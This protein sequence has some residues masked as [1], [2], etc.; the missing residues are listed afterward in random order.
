MKLA[1][2]V[3]FSYEEENMNGKIQKFF[4]S[5]KLLLA[6]RLLL[7]SIFVA[8]SIG[9]LQHPGEFTTLVASYNILPYSLA[10]I[11]GYLVPWVELIIGAFLILGIL[12]RFASAL[13]IPLIVS[14][15]IA[16]SH[17]LLIGAGGDVAA[18]V[19]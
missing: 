7:G 6:S 14:F 19:M 9:K 8:A 11:Y 12:T 13:S 3:G 10:A 5:E 17:R 16:S 2:E 1:L 4:T 15:L 18:S